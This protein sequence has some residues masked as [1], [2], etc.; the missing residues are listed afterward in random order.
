M[1]LN[2]EKQ[3]IIGMEGNILVTANPGTG[4]TLLLAGK[5]G[6]L[7]KKGVAPEDILCLTFTNKARK[8][9]EQRIVKFIADEKIQVDLGKLNVH[10]FHSF[11]LDNIEDEGILTS[12]LLRYVIYRYLREHETLNYGDD[13]LIDTIIPK[14]ESLIRYLKNFGI[15]PDMIDSAKAKKFLEENPRIE[16]ADMEKFLDEFI[17]IFKAYEKAKSGKGIDYTDMLLNFFKLKKPPVFKYVLVDELQDV[18]SIEADIA[19]R[20]G[21]KFFVVGDKKQAIFGFQGGSI[22]N[23]SKFKDSKSMVLSENYRNTDQVLDYA[24]A[25]FD[26][27]TK[28]VSHKEEL[29]NLRSVNG[30]KGEKPTIYEVERDDIPRAACILA[31]NIAAEG[32]QVAV[33]SRFNSQIMD[34]SKE[35]QARQVEHSTTYFSASQE[36]KENIIGFLKGMLSNDI[37]LIKNAM[38]TPFFPVCL[39]DAFELNKE[40]GLTLEKIYAAIPDFRKLRE[41]VKTAEDI[42]LLFRENI[43]P[44]AIC[45]GEDYLLASLSVQEACNEAIKVLDDKTIDNLA[46]YLTSSDMMANESDIEKGITVTTV[47]KAKGKQF[48]T[49]IYVPGKPKDQYNFQDSV[50]E[51]IL[52]SKG[53]NAVEELEE[54]S[55]R[56][57]FV[58]FT[59]AKDKLYVITD[60]AR[61]YV[62]ERAVNGSLELGQ[63]ETLELTELKK[64]AYNLF[65]NKNYDDAKRLLETKQ[66]WLKGFVK[67]H[68]DG[69][70]HIS[71]SRMKE[72]AYDY[73]VDSILKLG[74]PSLATSMGTD[75]HEI[76]EKMLKGEKYSVDEKAKPYVENLKEI[77]QEIK[78]R[79]PE[80]V[81]V[82]EEVNDVPLCSIIDTKDTLPFKGVI[83]AVFRNKDSYLIVDWKTS[84][85]D[86]YSA[87]YRQQLSVYQ[88]I[89]SQ[90][91]KIPLDKIKVAIGYI[92]LRKRINDG[93]IRREFDDKQ[94]A[95]TAFNTITKKLQKFLSW[96]DDVDQFFADLKDEKID[97]VLWRSVVEQCEREKAK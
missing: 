48:D 5:F 46:V 14:M 52:K 72:S 53:I 22:V 29:K 15:T 27:K 78:A 24:R 25:F 50:V 35:L 94:P 55:L 45:Y 65:V 87:D 2:Q 85:N 9:M 30:K 74:E 19:L 67:S 70:E 61:D 86:N 57:D 77:I 39:Q 69:L 18:N 16:K 63:E 42:N 62:N 7:L 10:T 43:L 73:L 95:G 3:K 1:E 28:E 66:S 34:I 80:V 58:A 33:I 36:A 93:I 49:V 76:A 83:D 21:E 13:Y 38:F 90:K 59:R 37:Q 47:H 60:K 6:D 54:E 17:N 97:D 89:Y 84:S 51:A 91:H 82:E 79:Y 23:F 32:R 88:R 26:S 56:V 44:V 31:M 41:S 8:E 11:S 75:V 20:S 71:F 12:N 40:K 81:A 64:R 92:G 96:K 68:F 4:K